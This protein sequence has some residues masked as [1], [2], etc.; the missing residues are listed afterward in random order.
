MYRPI[1]MK[2]T[3]LRIKKMLSE[4]GYDVKYIQSYLH[5]ACP[6]SIYRWF[7]GKILPSVEHLSALSELLHVSMNELLVLQG[8]AGIYRCDLEQYEFKEERL[9]AYATMLR[10]AA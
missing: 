2:K 9:L 3:G 10:E 4:A 8:A 6:Q 5:L 7:K 1:D